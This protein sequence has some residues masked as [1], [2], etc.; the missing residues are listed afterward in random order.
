[1]FRA[2]NY[3]ILQDIRGCFAFVGGLLLLQ[4]Q[5]KAIRFKAAIV[6]SRIIRTMPGTL[7][8][9][10]VNYKIKQCEKKNVRSNESNKVTFQLK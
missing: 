6:G 8:F 4:K 10:P 7:Y 1:M 3:R 9:V 5:R 2:V